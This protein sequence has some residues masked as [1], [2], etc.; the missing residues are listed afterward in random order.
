MISNFEGPYIKSIQNTYTKCFTNL[1]YD[2]RILFKKSLSFK[3][4]A[5]TWFLFSTVTVRVKWCVS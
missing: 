3:N 1:Y 5:S 4:A 2:F